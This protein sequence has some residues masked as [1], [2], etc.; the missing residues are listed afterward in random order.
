[1]QYLLTENFQKGK[2]YKKGENGKYR[3]D[4]KIGME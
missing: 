4:R 2:N 3:N 1:M